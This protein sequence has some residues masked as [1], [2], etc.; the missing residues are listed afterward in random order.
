MAVNILLVEDD[1][2]DVELLTE[3]LDEND[4]T[5]TINVFND[6]GLAS[7]YFEKCDT[8]P[9][10]IILDFNL[11]RVHGRELLKQVRSTP[12]F[13]NIP[14]LIL[15]TSS[16]QADIDAAYREGADMYLIKPTTIQGIN[17]VIS[18]ILNAIKKSSH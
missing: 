5:D 6:G 2:D 8:N 1:H 15:T 17:V 12:V 7:E 9:D 10:I 3:A 14:V 4:V 13:K 18:A 11:P 16:A